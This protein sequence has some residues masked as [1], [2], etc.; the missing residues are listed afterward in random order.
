MGKYEDKKFCAGNDA[1]GETE[2]GH[3][4]LNWCRMSEQADPYVLFKDGI[5]VNDIV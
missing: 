3:S 2:T 5:D 4:D 1:L